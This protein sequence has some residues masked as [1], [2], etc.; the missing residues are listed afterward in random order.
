MSF[1][2]I[3]IV[4]KKKGKGKGNPSYNQ[5]SREMTDLSLCFICEPLHVDGASAIK[6]TV[7]VNPN[8]DFKWS[9]SKIAFGRGENTFS[10]NTVDSHVEV[11]HNLIILSLSLQFSV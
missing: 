7:L 6:Y 11:E 9:A 4:Q 5:K 3:P 1:P 2:P 10:C 8:L